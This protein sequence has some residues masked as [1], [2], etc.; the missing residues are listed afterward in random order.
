MDKKNNKKTIVT[1]LTLVFLCVALC[2]LAA[3]LFLFM[4]IPPQ[5]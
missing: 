2:C 3:I 1:V 5:A 4:P